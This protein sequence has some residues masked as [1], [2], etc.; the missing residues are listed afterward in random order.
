MFALN[1]LWLNSVRNDAEL[2]SSPFYPSYSAMRTFLLQPVT[3]IMMVV[4]LIIWLGLI[5]WRSRTHPP[6][7][8]QKV[9]M[10][11]VLLAAAYGYLLTAFFKL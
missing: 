1:A 10:L 11:C 2:H 8:R 3:I 5:Y 6:T 7:D 4:G 9:A